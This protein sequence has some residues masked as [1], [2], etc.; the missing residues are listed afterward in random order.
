MIEF[1]VLIAFTDADGHHRVGS[2]VSLPGDG[3][4]GVATLVA[5]G[6]VTVAPE[7]KRQRKARS[8]VKQETT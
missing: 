2:R 8:T 3:H 1:E 7:P 5:Q 4:D 6:I